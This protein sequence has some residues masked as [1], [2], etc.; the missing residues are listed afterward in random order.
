[1]RHEH[2][3]R[4]DGRHFI[5]T[6]SPIIGADGRTKAI[7]VVSTDITDRVRAEEEQKNLQVQLQR[8]QKMEAMGL[9]AGMALKMR[10]TQTALSLLDEICK[11]YRGADAEF[12]AE[13]PN[14]P[15]H[16]HPEYWRYSDPNGPL[17]IL[18]REAFD[19]TVDWI[20][21]RHEALKTGDDDK[22]EEF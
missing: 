1:M 18:I 20:A 5:R 14:R 9:M 16:T 17:G 12:E 22:I 11:P 8:A 21:L 6:L 4:R 19:P 15:G 3:S 13:D 2:K 10:T 7:T